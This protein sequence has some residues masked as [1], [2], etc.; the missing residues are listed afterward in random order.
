MCKKRSNKCSAF[1]MHSNLSNNQLNI[2]CY[3]HRI[4]KKN[5]MVITNQKVITHTQERK[6]GNPTITLNK[7][8]KH[9]ERQ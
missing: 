8:M 5:P 3:I 6:K 1:R 4:S 2:N 7:I 9:E